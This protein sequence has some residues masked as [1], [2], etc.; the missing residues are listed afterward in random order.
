MT[1][2]LVVASDHVGSSL[3]A[4]GIRYLWFAR[5]L[6][7]SG[8]D[9]TL[10]V[11]FETNLDEGEF[12][13]AVD[14]PWHA[15]R[16]TERAFRH[17]AVVA[18]RLPVPT[19]LALTRAPTRAI[20]DLAAPLTIEHAAL[21][22]HQPR[23]SQSAFALDQLTLRVALETG[24]AFICASERQR[25]LWLG[26]LMAV[27]RVD[28][29]AYRCD[30]SF[31]ALVAVVPF[32]IDPSPPSSEEPVLKG[33]VPGIAEGDT[34]ALWGGGIWEWL[35]P[36]TVIR[37]VQILGRP[38]LKL[39]FL[40]TQSPNPAVPEMA[41]QRRAWELAADLGVLGTSVF[42]NDGWVPY[43]ERGPYLLEADVGVAAHFDELETRYAF[44]NRLLDYIWAGRPIVTTTGDTL[45]DLVQARSLGKTVAAGDV[46]AYAAALSAVLESEP[47]AY[48]AAMLRVQDE[49]AWPRVVAPLSELVTSPARGTAK[50]RR[51]T[52]TVHY[53][54][55]RSRV[56]LETRGLSGSAAR[57][58]AGVIRRIRGDHA[59]H[60]PTVERRKDGSLP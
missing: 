35:D 60:P 31:R 50:K 56:A 26:A 41:M 59:A 42:F 9:V 37:A 2:V 8:L 44:R 58:A 22:R 55:V 28:T 7:R 27:G 43:A 3:A 54:A 30:P 49:L 11:P 39:Y 15:R 36:L 46:A 47:S 24:D 23:G 52:R 10:V 1:S 34:V 21:A 4:P 19:M 33:V 48:A 14:N 38:D 40:G 18:Q 53:A 29:K 12:S 17:D 16:M 5:E 13:V 6:A 45:A 25:D 20:Y 57:L 51:L 32:G